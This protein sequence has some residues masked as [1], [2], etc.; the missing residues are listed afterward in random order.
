MNNLY[1]K[2]HIITPSEDTDGDVASYNA[3]INSLDGSPR[4]ILSLRHTKHYLDPSLSLLYVYLKIST[5]LKHQ[6]V[7][8]V[9][10]LKQNL[11]SKTASFIEAIKTCI[12][13]IDSIDQP[14]VLSSAWLNVSN[15]PMMMDTL[16]LIMNSDCDNL[17]TLLNAMNSTCENDQTNYINLYEKVNGAPYKIGESNTREESRTPLLRKYLMEIGAFT[18]VELYDD[19]DVYDKFIDRTYPE[20]MHKV[21]ELKD[22]IENFHL[23]KKSIDYYLYFSSKGILINHFLDT[24]L[25]ECD[26]RLTGADVLQIFKQI[27]ASAPEDMII[28]KCIYTIAPLLNLVREY[29]SYTLLAVPESNRTKITFNHSDTLYDRVSIKDFM[30]IQNYTN[31]V[32]SLLRPFSKNYYILLKSV[33]NLSPFT[34]NDASDVQLTMTR[35]K[36][37]F[38]LII[39]KELWNSLIKNNT[40]YSGSVLHLLKRNQTNATR[41]S[42]KNVHDLIRY[43]LFDAYA[44]SY[45]NKKRMDFVHLMNIAYVSH[46][47]A[48]I[49]SYYTDSDKVA[50][51]S[52]YKI[53]EMEALAYYHR[54]KP[55]FR[56][57]EAL[58]Y[59]YQSSPYTSQRGKYMIGMCFANVDEFM[60]DTVTVDPEIKTF[61]EDYRSEIYPI[62][63]E[64]KFKCIDNFL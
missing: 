25:Y 15:S 62:I 20:T 26:D 41:P 33:L 2:V 27:V 42:V 54:A 3:I 13:Y 53:H 39:T 14:L 47:V 58:I 10:L 49:L 4:S 28:D 38:N 12:D 7:N 50:I 18:D 31:T 11:S 44:S 23:S 51:A 34:I 17:L 59:L 48:D 22:I 56:E 8:L 46:A 63:D 9:V 1:E 45:K 24:N 60:H 43:V 30:R 29:E 61:Q 21:K 19:V 32:E 57:F 35:T 37:L 64:R 55:S 6:L 36:D 16:S 5:L 40:F 52:K